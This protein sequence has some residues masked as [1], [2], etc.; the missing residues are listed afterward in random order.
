MARVTV[1]WKA[2]RGDEA[3]ELSF[4]ATWEVTSHTMA[5]APSLPGS[6]IQ[7]ALQSP[8]GTWPLR[9][10]AAG[11]RTVAIAV[12]DLARPTPSHDILPIVL[13]ELQHA[14]IAPQAITIVLAVGSH[15]QLSDEDLCLKLGYEIYERCR[16]VQHDAWSDLQPLGVELG[17][18]PV[19]INRHFMA[20]ELKIL[21]GCITPHSFAGFSGGG[22]M[23]LPGLANIEIIERTHRSVVMGFKGGLG[24]V[25]GNQFRREVNDVCRQSGVDFNIDVVVNAKRQVA[26]IFAGRVEDA[27]LKGVDFARTVY[28]TKLPDSVDV[29]I[30]NAY[31]KDIDLIQSENA[32]HV[33]RSAKR[34]FVSDHGKVVL[35]SASCE[36]LGKH[37][38]FEPGGR[39]HHKPTR[40]R[41]L[42]NRELMVYCPTLERVEVAQFYWEGYPV[43]QTW[44]A[45][46]AALLQ[47]YPGPCRVA[48]F[49]CGA[50]QLGE[51]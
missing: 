18:F 39:L 4:P 32:F 5:D 21:L 49:P 26:G 2:W 41:W 6:Q 17:G 1:P 7:A 10:L 24:I 3:C 45:V 8:I 34:P 47:A 42:G 23:I 40:K 36:G 30:L 43:Y 48:V 51:Q 35:M 46:V 14:S 29:A 50:L 31:P 9:Q 37:G 13:N 19:K 28:R 16:I 12:D 11:K 25:E 44:D 27:Y 38:L 22:K 20:A 33:Y 15:P